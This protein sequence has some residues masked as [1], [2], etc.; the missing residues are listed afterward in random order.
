M[1]DG[2]RGSLSLLTIVGRICWPGLST[3]SYLVE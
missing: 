2:R 1:R 3:G